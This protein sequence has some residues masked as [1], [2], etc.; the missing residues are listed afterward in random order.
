MEATLSTMLVAG[1][2]PTAAGRLERVCR[3]ID[4]RLLALDGGVLVPPDWKQAPAYEVHIESGI[5]D[6]MQDQECRLW[7]R[8]IVAHGEE[9]AVVVYHYEAV[10]VV[11]DAVAGWD[12]LVSALMAGRVLRRW[13]PKVAAS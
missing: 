13:P 10:S 7:L 6:L 5:A 1:G 3:M 4:E 2:K 8:H 9:A 12:S 11:A